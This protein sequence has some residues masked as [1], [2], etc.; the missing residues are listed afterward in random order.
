MSNKEDILINIGSAFEVIP[1]NRC[2]LLLHMKKKYSHT[3]I[4]AT[5]SLST[6]TNIDNDHT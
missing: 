3:I 1:K 4:D 6:L 2:I 5:E